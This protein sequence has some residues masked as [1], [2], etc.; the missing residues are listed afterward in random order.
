MQKI[1]QRIS[2]VTLCVFGML[3]M[4]LYAGDPLQ[5]ETHTGSKDTLHVYLLIGQSNMAGRS[6]FSAD[7]TGV[8][9]GCYLLNGQ[10][11]WEPATNPLNRYSTIRKAIELQHL[12]P[13]YTFAKSML[14]Q[15]PDIS[16]GL[17][18]N[19]RGSTSIKEWAKG[20][21]YYNDAI[22]RTKTAQQTGTL[23]GILWHQGE[24]DAKDPQ[25]LEKLKVLIADLRK[26]LNAPDLPFIAGQ[27]Y[28]NPLINDQIA[29]LPEEM[30]FTGFASADE[31]QVKDQWH[32]T[33]ESTRIL[34]R[35]Y[36]TEMQKVLADLEN[37]AKEK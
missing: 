32:F 35:R 8:I 6:P 31:L 2:R 23:K 22:R 29:R 24:W 9:P 17:V 14:E 12:S 27:V 16:L 25:Y 28:N 7:E 36:A 21:A 20:T 11:E 4:V 26:D 10:D 18:V 33:P 5:K 30:P 13:G 19:A 3:A 15:N 37:A 34:G 1:R